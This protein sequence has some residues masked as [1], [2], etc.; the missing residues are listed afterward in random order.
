[1]T[2]INHIPN[3]PII[4]TILTNQKPQQHPILPS[5]A[6]AGDIHQPAHPAVDPNP[7]FPAIKYSPVRLTGEVDLY[8]LLALYHK[9]TNS[10]THQQKTKQNQQPTHHQPSSLPMYQTSTYTQVP[11]LIM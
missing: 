7:S 6:I 9:T 11:S 5:G 8:L 1:V 2:L 4:K 3:P 10:I